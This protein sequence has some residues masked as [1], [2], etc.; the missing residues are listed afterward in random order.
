[1]KLVSGGGVNLSGAELSGN[2]FDGV[3]ARGGR[4]AGDGVRISNN[5]GFG[6][7]VERDGSVDLTRTESSLQGNRAGRYFVAHASGCRSSDEGCR[8]RATLIVR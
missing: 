6:I 1:M 2:K 4:A 5:G 8:G 7:R 3:L